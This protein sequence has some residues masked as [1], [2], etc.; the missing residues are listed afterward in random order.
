MVNKTRATRSFIVH[1]ALTVG[2]AC[3]GLSIVSVASADPPPGYYGT[4]DPT[5]STTLR[6]TLHEVV[7]D[8]TRFPYTS[9]A[10]DTWDILELADEDPNDAN[11]ILDVYK[12]ASIAKFG[13]G[14]GPY[15][16]EHTWPS[17]YGFPNDNSQNIPYTDC[18]MLHLSDGSYNGSRGNKPYRYC[19]AGCA[20]NPTDVNNGQGGGTGVYPGNSN[21][22]AGAFVTGTWETWI[23]KRGN[24]ARALFYMDIRYEG[25][26]HGITG[27][28][29]PDLILTD[30]EALIDSSNTGSNESVA[31]MGMVSALL[32]WHLD[33]PVDDDERQRNDVVFS[34]QGNRNPFVDHPEWVACL[35]NNDCGCSVPAE[36]D[37][38]SYCNGLEDCVGGICQP[39]SDPCPGQSCDEETDTCVAAPDGDPWINELHYDNDGTDVGEFVEIAGPAGMNLAGWRVQGYNGSGGGVYSTMVEL[40]GVIPD[41]GGCTGVLAFAFVPMQNGS[42]DGLALIDD[43]GAVVQF[44]SYEG[45]FLATDG[46]ASGLTSV[47]IGVSEPTTTP[48][49]HSL[50]L[51]GVGAQSADFTWQAPAPHTQGL[52][53]NGQSFD[54]CGGC[55]SGPQCDDGLFCNGVETCVAGACQAGTLVDCDDGVACTIDSCNEATDS[56]D[57]LPNDAACDDGAFCNG[58]ETCD[59]LLDCQPSTPV[60]C[61]DGVSCTIDSCNE[62]TDL[63]DNVPNDSACDDAVFCNGAETC[64]PLLGCQPSTPVDCADG[65]SCTIDSCNEATDLCDN[66][67]NDAACDDG[68]FCN[69]GEYC[70][71]V[72][73]CQPGND[74]CPG[75]SCDEAGDV[76]FSPACDNDGACDP[77]EDCNTCPNDCLSGS[78]A[79]C[80]NNVC[81]TANGEDCVTCPEDC[82]SKLGGPPSGRYCCGDGTAAF[83]VTCAD[84]QCTGSG[85]SCTSD[86]ASASCCGDAFCEGSEDAAN[87]A[88]DCAECDV[89]GDCDDADAC[90]MDDCVA[91]VCANTPIN[92]DDGDACTIDGCSGGGCVYAPVNCD[93]G[94]SCSSDSCDPSTGCENVFPA[95]GLSDGCC[96]PECTPGNDPDCTCG[97]K[98]DPCSVNEECCSLNCRGNGRCG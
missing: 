14:V 38:G 66:V 84:S 26:T 80:G 22:T 16:R 97:A 91:G 69:G 72:L 93:D 24:V 5:N 28:A 88:V 53:N 30:S 61:D 89:P 23:G 35:F 3:C 81:E 57:N 50:Q 33:D 46:P 8:H 36:C 59:P 79:S 9:T 98:G 83:G 64:D 2:I 37:D 52:P 29:E 70:D 17:S 95:C 27:V 41:Q 48:I 51:S 60:E 58:A 44:I 7:D 56:C 20:E 25:G 94:D 71:P 85:N 6:A 77:G 34:F 54:G 75:Q 42:P 12:N 39:G 63:C 49:G 19:N 62:A 32:Q 86:P 67:P 47:D 11:N 68:A 18:H 15:E 92:C 1:C 73:G 10:T 76:C 78:G 21:W 4:V 87:C 55:T 82:N 45:T 74:P 65:V 31:Y 96:G 90:T 43:L 40:S 13:G